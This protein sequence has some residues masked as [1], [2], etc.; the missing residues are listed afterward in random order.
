MLVGL[1]R[2][3]VL[4]PPWAGSVTFAVFTPLFALMALPGARGPAALPMLAALVLLPRLV[5]GIVFGAL[6]DRYGATWALRHCLTF[7]AGTSAATAALAVL[8]GPLASSAA[9]HGALLSSAAIA[10][11][12]AW[13]LTAVLC[14]GGAEPTR[15]GRAGLAPQLG[16]LAAVV[17]GAGIAVGSRLAGVLLGVDAWIAGSHV[18]VAMGLLRLCRVHCGPVRAPRPSSAAISLRSW[19][20]VLL[21]AAAL[22]TTFTVFTMATAPVVALGAESAGSPLPV[23][24][25]GLVVVL[26]TLAGAGSLAAVVSDAYSRQHIVLAGTTAAT[27][28][29]LSA[30][31]LQPGPILLTSLLAVPAALPFGCGAALLPTLFPAGHR[32]VCVAMASALGAAGGAATYAWATVG[33]DPAAA[34]EPAPAVLAAV[35]CLS[36][37]CIRAVIRDTRR[38]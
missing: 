17:A 7:G 29:A 3:A 35:G 8:P 27:G 25:A 38:A 14:A 21:A 30:V 4:R 1:I 13:P 11:G 16:V 36:A 22:S 18:V 5:G 24:A 23:V 32:T 9:V 2:G 12:G 10:A 19:R 20:R 37:L 26:G 33:T 34:P 28:V 31:L 6:G 15:R